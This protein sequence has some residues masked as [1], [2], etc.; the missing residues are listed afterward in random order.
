M[1][2]LRTEA[3]PR[4]RPAAGSPWGP[5]PSSPRF[6]PGQRPA[7]SAPPCQGAGA[8]LP[9][10]SPDPEP[11]GPPQAEA[12]RAAIGPGPPG[13]GPTGRDRPRPR[14]CSGGRCRDWVLE[15]GRMVGSVACGQ[16]YGLGAAVGR[17]AGVEV[18][19]ERGLPLPQSAAEAGDLGHGAGREGLHDPLGDPASLD[20]V[21]VSVRGSESWAQ[22]QASQ[23]SRCASLAPIAA[24]S[25][26]LCRSEGSRRRRGAASGSRTTDHPCGRGVRGWPAGPGGGTHRRRQCQA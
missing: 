12:H 16:A 4:R 26:R 17:A 6:D 19:E 23:T 13:P 5:A 11:A 3:R 10:H 20:R 21:G 24:A 1:T 15:L 14:S 8:A 18:R 2:H 7:P 22:V 9:P 25:R